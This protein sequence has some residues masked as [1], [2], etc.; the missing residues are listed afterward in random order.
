MQ[1]FTLGLNHQSAPLAVRERIALNGEGLKGALREI[2][3]IVDRLKR[4]RRGRRQG[5]RES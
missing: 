3:K 1:L 2:G 5:N 4:E